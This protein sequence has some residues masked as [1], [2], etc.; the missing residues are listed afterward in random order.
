MEW[1]LLT[2]KQAGVALIVY[3]HATPCPVTSAHI[4]APNPHDRE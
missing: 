1:P 3:A 2:L 4:L